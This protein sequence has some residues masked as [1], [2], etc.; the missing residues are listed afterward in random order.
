MNRDSRR[1]QNSC[2]F[3]NRHPFIVAI[4]V[5]DMEHSVA[6]IFG[7]VINTINVPFELS[8]S[9]KYFFHTSTKPCIIASF[10]VV[11]VLFVV[12]VISAITSIVFMAKNIVKITQ[13]KCTNIQAWLPC[14]QKKYLCLCILSIGFSAEQSLQSESVS[15]SNSSVYKPSAGLARFDRCMS[16]S[17]C[18][19]QKRMNQTG[20]KFKFNWNLYLTND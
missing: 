20:Q 3:C 7:V 12:I 14:C 16:I 5:S 19:L 6:L 17:Q 10:F 18:Q 4:T 2:Q 9:T 1:K 13:K 8:S 15:L 11:V